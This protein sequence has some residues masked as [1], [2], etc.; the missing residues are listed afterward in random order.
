[1]TQNY[2]TASREQW[3]KAREALLA[4]EKELTGARDRVSRAPLAKLQAFRKRMGW[5]FK[6][7]SSFDNDF[8]RDYHARS[9]PRTGRQ[10]LSPLIRP[11][12]AAWTC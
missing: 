4:E 3:L 10:H 8:K 9:R 12:H 7:V 1:M 2:I 6:W 11:T 5:N